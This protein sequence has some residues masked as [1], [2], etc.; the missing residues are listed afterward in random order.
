MRAPGLSFALL[1]TIAL[2]VGSNVAVHRF[3][4]GLT[5][6]DSPLASVDR[7]VSVFARGGPMSYQEYLPLRNATAFEWI[8]A[9]RI[10]LE[11]V[12]WPGRSAVMPVAAV[13]PRLASELGL[14]L[15][16]GVVISQRIW[17]NDLRG[18]HVRVA[19]VDL[20]VS[21]MA[22]DSL[23]GVYRDSPI[24]I[25]MKLPEAVADTNSRNFWV[26]ARLRRGASFD[27]SGDSSGEIRVAPYTGMTP[28]MAGG[29][30]RV[31]T[32]L[33]LAAGLVFFIACANVA[34][35]LLGRATARSQETSVRVALGGSRGQLAR[36]LLSDSVVISV[37]GGAL[38]VLLATWTS[39]VLPALL[40]V[41]DAQ[42]LVARPDLFGIVA[43]SAVCAGIA[44]LCGLL[45]VFAISHD[46]PAIV[47]RRES[48]GPSPTIRRLRVG[49]VVAQM[50]GCCILVIATAFLFESL[51]TALETSVGRR[52]GQPILASVMTADAY[53]ST[54]YFEAVES[55]AQIA[56]VSAMTWTEQLPGGLPAWR[57]FR[58]EPQ[59]LES[60]EVTMDIDSFTPDTLPVFAL[61]PVAGHFFGV[62]DQTCRSAVANEDAARLLFGSDTPGRSI[63]EPGGLAVEIIGVL[64]LRK[65][66]RRPTIYHFQ[67]DWTAPPKGRIAAAHFRVPM[68]SKLERAELGVNVVAPNYFAAMGWPMVAGRIFPD[69][70][71]RR[72]CREGMVNEEA[73]DLYFHG[74]A[75]GSAVIDDNGRRTGIIGVVRSTPLG[76][77]EPRAEP[78][79][80]FP[81]VQDCPRMMTL[82]LNARDPNRALLERLT[83]VIE[84]VPGRGP[85]PVLVR[86][87]ETYLGQTALAPLRIATMIIG[88]SATT[89]FLLSVLGLFGALNDAQR[90]R[91]RELAIRIAL[92]AR[93]R[94]MIF[95]VLREGGRLA[96][97][98][99]LAGTLGSLALSRMLTR[100]APG[101]VLPPLWVWLAAPLVLAGA[102]VIASV[103]PARSASIVNPV[104][105]M[106]DSN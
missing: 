24:D 99:I 49:L 66:T 84:I 50:T 80:Y 53:G 40:F 21:G 103:L 8:G 20:R 90:Q 82:I 25:W 51:H 38:G 46:R 77:F 95:L 75:V 35:F 87:L 62:A 60:R 92:G 91:R 105:I 89:A 106:S 100:I 18:G 23:E 13:T 83:G 57:S 65:I 85:S 27:G 42:H 36:G 47:L 14:R 6:P 58:V 76:T 78:S 7:V 34:S 9:A 22:P 16:D 93:R 102:V 67:A 17:Q 31:G 44:I 101:N 32:L 15:D 73:A 56:G 52:L 70:P 4:V 10:S 86:T 30:A 45:P 1:L 41:S 61:P 71:M 3:V 11:A 39:Y 37:A 29:I 88:A 59:M 33:D 68:L 79:I 63:T 72:G 74:N 55:A 69:D 28:E 94:H 104:T 64:G 5:W 26:L 19:G 48:A 54:R 2:G 81:M 43:A 12:A 96:C 98:G 97:A